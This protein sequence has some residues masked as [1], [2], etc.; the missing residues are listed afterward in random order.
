MVATSMTTQAGPFH[1]AGCTAGCIQQIVAVL[2]A[3][4]SVASNFEAEHKVT[5]A[6]IKL[7]TMSKFK[8]VEQPEAFHVY[9]AWS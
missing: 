6:P 1:S 9:A 3:R 2:C 5:T 7:L 8:L 4:K